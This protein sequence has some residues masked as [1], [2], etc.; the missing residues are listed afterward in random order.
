MKLVINPSLQ[1]AL[2]EKGVTIQPIGM[3]KYGESGE[4]ESVVTVEDSELLRYL[5]PQAVEPNLAEEEACD[6]ANNYSEDNLGIELGATY[7]DTVT[8]FTGI[9]TGD[10]TYLTC[11][12]QVQLE[13]ETQTRW[14]DENRL[15][16]VV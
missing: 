13:N 10:C 2:L 15:D 16:K 8:G 12:N 1:L 5:S 6:T 9:A 4:T 3:I 11:E 7:V 14:F